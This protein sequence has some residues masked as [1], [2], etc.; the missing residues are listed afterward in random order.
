MAQ[1]KTMPGSVLALEGLVL[2]CSLI[3]F[4]G[5]AVTTRLCSREATLDPGRSLWKGEDKVSP[6][7][8]HL[9]CAE[10]RWKW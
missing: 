4:A 9:S 2:L 6:L 3:L 1:A 5:T 7:Q 10:R 8:Q